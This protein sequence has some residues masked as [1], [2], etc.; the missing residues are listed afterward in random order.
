MLTIDALK[1]LGADT[2]SGVAR[3]VGDEGFYLKM[4]T[5]A[6]GDDS[7]DQLKEAIESNSLEIA[8]ERAHAL[9]GVLGNVGL[10]SLYEPIAKMTEELRAHKDID[11]SDYL[12]TI[13]TE[14]K[15][16]RDLL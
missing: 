6:L 13:G 16:Y 14:L 1:E 8:F 11:Y 5:M 10:T 7:F 4:V 3:C 2:A 9:K 12:T 15:K